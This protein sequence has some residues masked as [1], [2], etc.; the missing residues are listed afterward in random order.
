MLPFDGQPIFVGEGANVPKE[1]RG[2]NAGDADQLVLRPAAEMPAAVAVAVG[3]R[4][5]L[6]KVIGV[7]AGVPAGEEAAREELVLRV[8][9]VDRFD[10][11]VNRHLQRERIAAP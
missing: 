2:S 4:G 8:K 7:A 6:E 5:R 3:Y 1:H 9:P 11:L 10:L